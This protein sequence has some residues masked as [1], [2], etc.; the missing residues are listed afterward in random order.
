M[1]ISGAEADEKLKHKVAEMQ[2]QLREEQAKHKIAK[3]AL[4]AEQ[5]HFANEI[6]RLEDLTRGVPFV[7]WKDMRAHHTG[8]HVHAL[9]AS[10]AGKPPI[11][12]LS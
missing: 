2:A 12:T 9:P 5:Q 8:C 10:V 4:L 7:P 3:E 11:C 1:C 6:A